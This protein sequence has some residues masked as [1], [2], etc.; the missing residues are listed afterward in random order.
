MSRICD[1]HLVHAP[2]VVCSPERHHIVPQAWQ[3][4]ARREERL[5][6][7]TTVKVPPTCHRNVHFYIVKLMKLLEPLAADD[8]LVAWQALKK[9]TA[10]SRCAYAGL[11]NYWQAGYS[12]LLLCE[13]KLYGYA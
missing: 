10:E 1:L 3:H 6:L 9:N 2:K 5:F 13:A 8:P 4:F 11:M 12:L 7:P